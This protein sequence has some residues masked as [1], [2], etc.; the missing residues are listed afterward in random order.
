MADRGSESSHMS[1]HMTAGWPR[2]I[3][4]L[5]LALF[6]MLQAPSSALA[7]DGGE[8]VPTT[9]DNTQLMAP[10]LIIVAIVLVVIGIVVARKG[11]HG[12]DAGKPS[13][14]HFKK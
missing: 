6:G 8:V 4:A 1:V 10:A 7:V 13:G 5:V 12:N 2:A 11:K 14:S 9:S 3:P